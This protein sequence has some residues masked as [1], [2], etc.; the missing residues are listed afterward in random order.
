VHH[1][2]A[3]HELK[4]TIRVIGRTT[5]I[6]NDPRL[7]ALALREIDLHPSLHRTENSVA[8]NASEDAGFLMERVQRRGGLATYMIMGSD[9]AAPHHSGDF[10]F[11]ERALPLAV[12][13][14]EAIA[15]STAEGAI[16]IP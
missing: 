14:L 11:D 2:A 13:L 1:S 12:E 8:V 15:R 4:E 5:T 6:Q 10:D 3:M 7:V 9:I 16:S